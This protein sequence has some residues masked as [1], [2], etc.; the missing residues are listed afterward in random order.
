MITET[1]L[2]CKPCHLFF[3]DP[4]Y[5]YLC[6]ECG[7]TLRRIKVYHIEPKDLIIRTPGVKIISRN[8]N[9]RTDNDKHKKR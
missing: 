6:P 7:E 9:E 5:L 2:K 3:K 4:G 1:K 8:P